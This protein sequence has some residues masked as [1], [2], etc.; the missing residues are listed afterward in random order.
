M[1]TPP[2]RC[3]GGSVPTCPP[4]SSPTPTTGPWSTTWTQQ[5]AGLV[6]E[7]RAAS[8]Q[9]DALWPV[10]VATIDQALQRG[11]QLP[12]L[13]DEIDHADPARVG[14]CQSLIW[15]T[16]VLLDPPPAPDDETPDETPPPVRR[17]NVVDTTSWRR[18]HPSR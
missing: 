5:L 13:L 3:G 2:E 7:D 10:L 15:R 11:W 16:S 12:D 6:G 18:R 4:Q 17:R 14:E 9:H 8:L 1:T